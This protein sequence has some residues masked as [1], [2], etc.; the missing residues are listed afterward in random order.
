MKRGKLNKKLKKKLILNKKTILIAVII[1]ALVVV[2][3]FYSQRPKKNPTKGELLKMID[4]RSKTSYLNTPFIIILPGPLCWCNGADIDH[5]GE[6]NMYDFEILAINWLRD[7][8]GGIVGDVKWCD[9][10]DINHD[11]KVDMDDYAILANNW[12]RTDCTQGSSDY[13]GSSPDYIC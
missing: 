11:G 7:D 6:V 12:G 13:I 9:G 4:D 2:L 1:I 10:A 5:D 3:M 8:C